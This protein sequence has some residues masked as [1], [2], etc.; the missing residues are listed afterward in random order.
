MMSL[1]DFARFAIPFYL[2]LAAAFAWDSIRAGRFGLF[3]IVTIVF[4]LL[5]V[6][7]WAAWAVFKMRELLRRRKRRG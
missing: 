7:T 6:S 2:L 4:V 3:E 1:F 5:Y